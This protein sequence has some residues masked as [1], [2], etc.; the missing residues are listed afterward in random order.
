MCSSDLTRM[1]VESGGEPVVEVYV[2]INGDAEKRIPI[3]NPSRDETWINS[4]GYYKFSLYRGTNHT[5]LLDS[6]TVTKNKEG[7]KNPVAK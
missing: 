5:E 4:G 6:V 3:G 2:S 7:D 1:T